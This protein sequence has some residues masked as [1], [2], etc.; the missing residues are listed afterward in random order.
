MSWLS[1]PTYLQAASIHI[2]FLRDITLKQTPDH[3]PSTDSKGRPIV[4]GCLTTDRNHEVN[5]ARKTSVPEGSGI[6]VVMYDLITDPSKMCDQVL[7]TQNR[8]NHGCKWYRA[9]QYVSVRHKKLKK[10]I[11]NFLKVYHPRCVESKYNVQN[12]VCIHIYMQSKH[13]K[14]VRQYHYT[15]SNIICSNYKKP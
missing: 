13:N 12:C 15:I 3:L 8:K 10:K 9:Q 5:L 14:L 1:C 7:D 2:S 4:L 11:H 6:Q